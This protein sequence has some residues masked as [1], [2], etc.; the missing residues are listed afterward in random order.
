MQTAIGRMRQL[1]D[2]I[3]GLKAEQRVDV[4]ALVYPR[5]ARHG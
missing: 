4:M 1:R 5:D 3:P 2:D